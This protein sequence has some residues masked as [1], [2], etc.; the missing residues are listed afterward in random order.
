[1]KEELRKKVE[2][3]SKIMS[4]I[5]IDDWIRAIRETRDEA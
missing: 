5:E 2:L 4:K 3:A 1:M